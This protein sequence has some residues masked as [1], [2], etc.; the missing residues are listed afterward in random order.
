MPAEIPRDNHDIKITVALSAKVP[1]MVVYVSE[2]VAAGDWLTFAH[3]LDRLWEQTYF[4][5]MRKAQDGDIRDAIALEDTSE[6]GG[7]IRAEVTC[8]KCMDVW[9][10]HWIRCHLG[11]P[12][13]GAPAADADEPK[14]VNFREFL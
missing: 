4:R 14:R 10:M 9:R 3:D 12:Q 13:Q 5:G 2:P 11:L 7:V 1:I 6:P 8:K